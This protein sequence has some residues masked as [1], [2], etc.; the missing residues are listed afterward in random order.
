MIHLEKRGIRALG[1]AES[2]KKEAKDSILAGVIMRSDLV[3]DGI[4][5][6]KVTLRGDDATDVIL[7][8]YNSFSRNDINL[9]IIDGLIISM[10]NIIDID[11]LY[12]SIRRPIIAITFNES[13]GLNEYIIRSF[14]ESYEKKLIAYHK[15]GYR[16]SILLKSGYLVY[17]RSRG[18]DTDDSKRVIDRFLLQGSIPEP[19]RVAK[20]V[21]R[22]YLKF[23][24]S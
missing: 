16:E 19:I 12:E 3:I 13:K 11:L 15:L 2:F 5:V 9:I 10:Y 8:L 24:S 1:I 14:P 7:D 20:L 18:L 4:M 22:A 6:R 21:S 17:I 23:I